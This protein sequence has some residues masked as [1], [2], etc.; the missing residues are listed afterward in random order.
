MTGKEYWAKVRN[1]EDG[2]EGWLQP[3]SLTERSGTSGGIWLTSQAF[4][5]VISWFPMVLAV[6]VFLFAF[7]TMIS[8]SY[9][10]EQA[11]GF[12]TN[13]NH[14]VT[15]VYKFGFCICVE[16]VQRDQHGHAEFSCIG[17]MAFKV[18][19]PDF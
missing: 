11:L 18:G 9:Y 12:L 8:W 13:E 2:V 19:K 1:P 6:A 4:K 17:N 5:G 3:G 16:A 14:I 7:S 15:L 10:G